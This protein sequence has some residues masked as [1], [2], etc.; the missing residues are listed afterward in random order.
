MVTDP[1]RVPVISWL[2]S[3]G[4]KRMAS[5]AV[6]GVVS[7]SLVSVELEAVGPDAQTS[8]ARFLPA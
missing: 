6:F 5:T 4:E 2:S 7:S 1:S 8:E 3:T